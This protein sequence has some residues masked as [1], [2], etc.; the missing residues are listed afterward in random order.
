MKN[1]GKLMASILVIVAILMTMCVPAM[2]EETIIDRPS[3]SD[4]ANVT[5]SNLK[6]GA[7]VTL[8]RIVDPEYNENGFTGYKA[9][10]VNGKTIANVAAPTQTEIEELWTELKQGNVAGLETKTADVENGTATANVGAGMW[11]AIV[12]DTEGTIYNPMIV[13]VNYTTNE[14]NKTIMSGADISATDK[15]ELEGTQLYAKSS[16]PSVD[17]KVDGKDS[18]SASVGDKVN[19]TITATKPVYPENVINKTFYVKDTMSAG[20][21]LDTDSIKV[22]GAERDGNTFKVNGEV[23]ANLKADE[24]GFTLAFVYDKVPGDPNVTYSAIINEEAVVG[25]NGNK[26]NVELVY[27]NNPTKGKTWDNP[28]DPGDPEPTPGED[29][30][31]TTTEKDVV[32]YTYQLAFKKVDENKKPLAGAQFG[33]YDKDDNLIDVVTTSADGVA[34]SSKV[35]EGTYTIKEIKAPAGYSLNTEP[36]EITANQTSAVRTTTTTTRTY[37]TTKPND[38]AKQVGWLKG[39]VF[40]SMANQPE[41]GV[42]AYIGSETRQTTTVD[43]GEAKGNGTAVLPTDISNTKV[44]E[45]PSTGGMGT[46]LFVVGGVAVMA[47]AVVLI[48]A[49]K[50]RAESK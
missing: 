22:E 15:L 8:Y 44:S 18:S 13:S 43:E 25:G 39:G 31:L 10:T 19:Y 9:K 38:D 49:N 26:N 11:I 40:Y 45:L 46:T 28:N 50:R 21:T 24:H 48:A 20:L 35:G 37:V 12:T 33:I 29:S 4:S 14:G 17:K 3:A 41:G 2:A 32:V 5:I 42:P 7:Q 34:V 1:F 23:I 27:A 6:A 30:G 36:F 47:L 16:S